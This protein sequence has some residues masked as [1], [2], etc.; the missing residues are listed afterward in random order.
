MTCKHLAIS[1]RCLYV[2]NV[3]EFI[4]YCAANTGN[5]LCVITDYNYFILGHGIYALGLG[6]YS[7]S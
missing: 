2:G 5:I 7:N 3:V 1:D 6:K 4:R